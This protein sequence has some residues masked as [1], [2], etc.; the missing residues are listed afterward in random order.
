MS[1]AFVLSG[2]AS[3]GS[4]QV[5]MLAALADRGI[6]PDLLVG[7]SAGA[8]NAA[9]LAGRGTDR[10]A[11]DDLAAVWRSLR[12]RDVFQPDPIR[13]A[14]SLL[15]RGPA[16]F[17]NHG[18]RRLIGHHLRFDS[19]EDAGIALAVVTADLLTGAEVT[20]TEGPATTAVLASSAIPAM[21][22]P[23]NWGTQTLVDG[24]LADNTAI[25]RAVDAGAET[26]YVLPCGYPCA[27]TSP[28]RSAL[29]TALQAM[30]LLVHQRLIHDIALYA[31]V[32]ELIVVPP[33]CPLSVA[34][35]DFRQGAELIRRAHAAA[36]AFLAVDGGRRA[37]PTA[38]IGMHTHRPT[39][40]QKAR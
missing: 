16:L 28:P 10:D 29:A 3:L 26:I 9:Y 31:S 32:A 8:L 11:V 1:T 37:D 23:V 17:G 21:L 27:L 7:T 25:S 13:L 5:G 35:I 34:P 12:T 2:G 24:G 38:H 6:A 33:P 4:V 14:T 19:I 36:A 30:S 40:T 20:L 39:D 18:L 22:P 15:G